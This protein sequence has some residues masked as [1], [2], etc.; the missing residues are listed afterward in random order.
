MSRKGAPKATERQIQSGLVRWLKLVLPVGSVVAASMNEAAASSDDPFARARYYERRKAAGVQRGW[1]DLTLVLPG[2]IV[3][4]ETKRPAGGV[5]SEAQ[6]L[7]HEKVR[8][9]GHPVGVVVDIESARWFLREEGVALR[10]AVGQP[11][12]P[13]SVRLAK[14]MTADEIPF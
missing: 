13:V 14:R 8:A 9:L 2:R 1:F 12:R 7:V 10:E 5:L 6:Q 11:A 3:F 4:L